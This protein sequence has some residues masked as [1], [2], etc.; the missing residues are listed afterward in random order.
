MSSTAATYSNL[1]VSQQFDQVVSHRGPDLAVDDGETA[2]SYAELAG[3]AN[4]IAQAILDRWGSANEPVGLLFGHDVFGIA[5]I[6]A[7]MRAGKA[8]A[9]LDPTMPVSRNRA[10]LESAECR[11]LLTDNRHRTQAESIAGSSWSVINVSSFV[12]QAVPHLPDTWPDPQSLA[13]INFTSGSTGQPK[14]IR[15]THAYLVRR[16]VVDHQLY[17]YRR[18]ETFSC[19]YGFSYGASRA[20][21]FGSLLTG[22]TLQLFDVR[23]KGVE[24]MS[25]WLKQSHVSLLHL[26]STLLRVFL[27]S[28]PMGTFFPHVRLVRPSQ[29]LLAAD[30]ERLWHVLPDDAIVIHQYASSETGPV[31][32]FTIDRQTELSDEVVP[33]GRPLPDVEIKLVDEQGNVVSVGEVGEIVV[34]SPYLAPEIGESVA[35]RSA[36]GQEGFYHTGD[37]G[38]IRQ[39]GLMEFVGRVDHLV[40]VRGYRVSLSSIETALLRLAQ[41]NDAVVVAYPDPNGDRIPVAY[42]VP[43]TDTQG[44]V[45]ELRRRLAEQLPP[46]ALP[47][48]FVFLDNLPRLANGKIDYAAL[49]QVD[50]S[51]PALEIPYTAPRTPVETEVAGIWAEALGLDQVGIHDNFLELGGHSL[52]AG[53]IVSRV[54]RAFQVDVPLSLLFESPT[55]AEMALAITQRQ[56]ARLDPAALER[57]LAE[58]E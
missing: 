42:I 43:T 48:R 27:D 39:D 45:P 34:R 24:Q 19:L 10:L 3:V 50:G 6:L 23:Q 37:L 12:G 4:L 28:L 5:A 38:R 15:R 57:L 14:A 41:V 51:R 44:L 31:S 58:L 40:K 53:R 25:S 46:Y 8:Y 35:T 13:V 32:A 54:M 29:R 33:V 21:L 49:P 2:W 20:A 30:I 1:S 47:A 16:A 11:Y 7:V 18:N 36:N 52:L 56:A 55:V 22:A 26:N 9:A 17:G